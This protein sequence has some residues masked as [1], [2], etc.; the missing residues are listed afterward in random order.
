MPIIKIWC[1]PGSQTEDDLRHLHKEI[2]EAVVS[3][4]ELGLKDETQMVCL[5][6]P[7]M[8]KY[9]LG[10]EVIVEVS[11]LFEKPER[12][13]EV[14]NRLAQNIGEKVKAIYQKAMVEVLVHPFNPVINGFWKAD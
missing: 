14:R 1:L 11:G 9:G 8:M 5:F 2:V 10:S 3:I 6:P 13:P 4:P 7:D 12:T